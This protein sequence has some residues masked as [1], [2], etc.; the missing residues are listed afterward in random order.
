[1]NAEIQTGTISTYVTDRGWGFISRAVEQPLG[2]CN[3]EK[4][5]FHVSQ[6][7][8]K[9]IKPAIGVAVSFSISP[10]I[11]GKFPSALDVT[12]IK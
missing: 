12:P 1:M 8:S 2:H 11:D 3:V 6:F 5:F 4:F 7:R 10:V 9:D